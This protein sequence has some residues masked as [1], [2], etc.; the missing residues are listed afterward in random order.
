MNK[1]IQTGTTA[2]PHRNKG[3]SD[4]QSGTRHD[5]V[6]DSNQLKPTRNAGCAAVPVQTAESLKGVGRSGP[7]PKMT[8]PE[9]WDEATVGVA[10]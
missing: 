8:I 9:G 6:P 7:A 3:S 5:N 4:S 10:Q 1:R 2:Q